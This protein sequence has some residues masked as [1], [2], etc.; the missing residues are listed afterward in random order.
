MGRAPR[1]VES[2]R[3][4]TCVHG[5]NGGGHYIFPARS[6][7]VNRRQTADDSEAYCACTVVGARCH[8]RPLRRMSLCRGWGTHCLRERCSVESAAF[9]ALFSDT[10]SGDIWIC[11]LKTSQLPFVKM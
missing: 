11:T 1:L 3:L 5:I 7:R 6:R 9:S 8:R 2:A 10:A 4:T